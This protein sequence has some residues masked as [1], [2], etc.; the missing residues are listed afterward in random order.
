MPTRASCASEP[1][2]AAHTAFKFS[3]TRRVCVLMSPVTNSPLAG[4]SGI[5]P[6]KYTVLP[7]RTACEYG[8][9]AFGALSVW[10]VL[11]MGW[12]GKSEVRT[13]VVSPQSRN[14]DHG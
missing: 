4:S 13:L 1:P 9:I 8:P 10:M 11:R 7:Q 3:N 2:A 14:P 5:W 6:E 12:D